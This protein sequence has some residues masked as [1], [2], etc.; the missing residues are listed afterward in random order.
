MD[1]NDANESWWPWQEQTLQLNAG[2][3]SWDKIGAL[4][5]K[6]GPE[7]ER[8][9]IS[10]WEQEVREARYKRCLYD[11]GSFANK[12]AASIVHDALTKDPWYSHSGLEDLGEP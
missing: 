7:C 10:L 4:M 9:F 3:H 1:A 12:Q 6:S 2:R 5:G 11:E 8:K